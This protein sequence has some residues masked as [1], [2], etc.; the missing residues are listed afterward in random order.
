MGLFSLLQ[1]QRSLRAPAVV[2]EVGPGH[3]RREEQERIV[4]RKETG[5]LRFDAGLPKEAALDR[6]FLL[7]RNRALPGGAKFC[8]PRAGDPYLR[9]DLPLR[10]EEDS[11]EERIPAAR[12]C[13]QQILQTLSRPVEPVHEVLREDCPEVAPICAEAGIPCQQRGPGRWVVELER[14]PA[15]CQ[16]EMTLEEGHIALTV[17]LAEWDGTEGANG[18][19][20]LTHLLLRAGDVFRMVCGCV[21]TDGPKRRALLLVRLPAAHLETDLP[22]ALNAL[23]VAADRLQR[24]AAALQNP[25]IA[26]IYLAM[27]TGRMTE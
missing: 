2:V 22:H 4:F 11:G 24:E 19:A 15:F 9:L 21:E 7:A 18:R 10:S 25:E 26:G 27:Q 5:W 8:L 23:S 20:A 12:A 17:V 13:M 1:L 16:A 6:E 14:A 3:R